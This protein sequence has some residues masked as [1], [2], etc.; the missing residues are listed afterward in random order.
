MIHAEL[1]RMT[2]KYDKPQICS[3]CDRNKRYQ[4]YAQSTLR[5]AVSHGVC[6]WHKKI[7]LFKLKKLNVSK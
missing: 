7:F 2:A 6:L 4:Y 1:K 5:H 3:W